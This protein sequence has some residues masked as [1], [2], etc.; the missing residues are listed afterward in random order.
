[1]RHTADRNGTR[2]RT[3][4]RA[5]VGR[6]IRGMSVHAILPRGRRVIGAAR[7]CRPSPAF[8]S[9]EGAAAPDE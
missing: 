5:D 8:R 6:A 3:G 9:L 7:I 4:D 1:M 2:P